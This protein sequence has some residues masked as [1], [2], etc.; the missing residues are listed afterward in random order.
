MKK[1]SIWRYKYFRYMIF[2]SPWCYFRCMIGAWHEHVPNF[3]HPNINLVIK[4]HKYCLPGLC[5]HST[6]VHHP[7][8][9][10][11]TN[12]VKL[13]F[14]LEI[15]LDKKCL[16]KM[17]SLWLRDPCVFYRMEIIFA[18]ISKNWKMTSINLLFGAY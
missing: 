8:I 7:G 11:S 1:I 10:S 3:S 17:S 13:N 9:S 15:L 4:W 5:H 16:L 6:S 2:C 14:T 18:D 12:A